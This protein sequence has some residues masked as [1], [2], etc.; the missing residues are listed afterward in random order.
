M[1]LTDDSEFIRWGKKFFLHGD[2]FPAPKWKFSVRDL[3]SEIYSLA[4]WF[5]LFL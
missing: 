5:G 2:N 3:G 4:S 1:P